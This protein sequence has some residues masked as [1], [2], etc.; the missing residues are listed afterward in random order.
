V[1]DI[2]PIYKDDRLPDP[3]SFA[4]R[5]AWNGQGQPRQSDEAPRETSEPMALEDCLKLL[6]Q[7]S[8]EAEAA[9]D[10]R[11]LDQWGSSKLER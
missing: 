7:D 9:H 2:P 1:T 3:P 6:P 4:N 8:I 10:Q 5:F 11:Q